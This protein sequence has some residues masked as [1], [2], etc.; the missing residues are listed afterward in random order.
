MHATPKLKLEHLSKWL[1]NSV[2]Y[3]IPYSST[4]TTS[5]TLVAYHVVVDILAGVKTLLTSVQA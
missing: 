5:S 2:A 3:V 4:V 1:G